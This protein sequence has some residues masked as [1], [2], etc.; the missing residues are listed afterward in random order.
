M[1]MTWDERGRLWLMEYRQYPDV[2]GLEMVSRDIH[3]RTVY[4]KVPPP[5]PNHVRGRDRISVHADTDGD[6][7]YDTH[8][9]FVDGLNLATSLAHGRGGVWVTKDLSDQQLR[10]LFAYFRASQ[11]VNY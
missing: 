3:P 5:P 7:V 1:I 10:D 6:G 8:K 9:V 11:P 4:D 2:A